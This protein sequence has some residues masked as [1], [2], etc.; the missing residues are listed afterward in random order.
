M[1]RPVERPGTSPLSVAG[2]TLILLEVDGSPYRVELL[3]GPDGDYRASLNGDQVE[4][5]IRLMQAGVL[6][7]I[8][9]D[10]VYRCLLLDTSGETVVQVGSARFPFRQEDRRSLGASRTKQSAGSAS[11]AIKAP[12]PGRVIRLLVKVG[13]VVEANQGII[14]IEAMKMQNELKTHRSGR[15]TRI[16]VDPGAAI[17]AN[18]TLV[19]IE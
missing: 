16:E 4:F 2:A 19:V 11:Q 14:V 13:E 17:G 3:A 15:V 8:L 5:N 12:M 7:L 1:F 6:S 9:N 18:Q 10:R